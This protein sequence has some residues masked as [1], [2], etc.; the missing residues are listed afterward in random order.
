MTVEDLIEKTDRKLSLT[1]RPETA[2]AVFV[3][4]SGTLEFDRTRLDTDRVKELVRARLQ[5]LYVDVRFDLANDEFCIT[6]LESDVYDRAGIER[7]VFRRLA[8]SDSVLSQYS[9]QLA[10]SLIDVKSIAI[11]GGDEESMDQ[12]L[13]KAF[14][15][16]KQPAVHRTLADEVDEKAQKMIV[17]SGVRTL[18]DQV[19]E[20]S[21][22]IPGDGSVWDWRKQS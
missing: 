19:E 11:R 15:G 6:G 1:V 18:A 20:K 7:E 16:L 10:S 8:R 5:P 17:P 9:D 13:R 2:P 22:K 21:Q 14:D 12:V 3:I 4:F